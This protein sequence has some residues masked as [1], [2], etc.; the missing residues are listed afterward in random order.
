MLSEGNILI[1]ALKNQSK[2]TITNLLEKILKNSKQ[3]G[4]D[5]NALQKITTNGSYIQSTNSILYTGEPNN[6]ARIKAILASIDRT[7]AENKSLD[8]ITFFLYEPKDLGIC[9]FIQIIDEIA[10]NLKDNNYPNQ[11]LL[12]SLSNSTLIEG[13]NSV[14][15][16]IAN[17]SRQELDALLSSVTSSYDA[18]FKKVG[19]SHFFLYNIKQATEEQIRASLANLKDYLKNNKYPN[20]N[21]INSISSIKWIKS[22]NSYYL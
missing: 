21:L 13:I 2:K 16:I 12:H 6:L 3:Q 14:L 7:T 11:D 17:K 9:E 8:D 15:F 1:Y 4:I 22:S 19:I 5:V 10:E 18:D 20:E